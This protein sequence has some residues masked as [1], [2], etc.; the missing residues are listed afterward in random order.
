VAS[1]LSQI[2]IEKR[3]QVAATLGLFAMLF[4][5]IGAVA[6]TG[7]ATAVIRG[8]VVVALVVAV[9]LGLMAWGVLR[10]IKL[11]RDEAR[12]DA[13]IEQAVRKSGR[14]MCDCGHEHDPDELH[15]VDGEGTH[16][17]GAKCAH[18]GTGTDC[19]HSCE[20]CVLAALRPSPR[21]TRAE[22]IQTE[23]TAPSR[24]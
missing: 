10:S 9:L 17:T 6:A 8:F 14:N 1:P 2:E 7:P 15:F 18:D 12:L 24:P 3:R 13:A 5:A 23:G 19:S 16:L 4:I 20:T 22:R 21:S 11:D